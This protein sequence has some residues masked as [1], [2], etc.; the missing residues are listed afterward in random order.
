MHQEFQQLSWQP[1][2]IEVRLSNLTF[3]GI[4]ILIIILTERILAFHGNCIFKIDGQYYHRCYDFLDEHCSFQVLQ[5][6]N[7]II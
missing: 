2:E 5:S 4:C 3:A 1:I 7:D 6:I